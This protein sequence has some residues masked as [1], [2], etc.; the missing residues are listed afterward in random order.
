MGEENLGWDNTGAGNVGLANTGSHNV[1]AAFA[2]VGVV[3][4]SVHIPFT[5]VVSDMTLN[6]FT[7]NSPPFEAY[8]AFAPY[9]IFYD[10]GPV[11]IDTTTFDPIPLNFLWDNTY[12]YDIG[13]GTF[14]PYE[15]PITDFSQQRWWQFGLPQLLGCRPW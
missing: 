6:E 14:G 13:P 10:F 12:H 9:Y 7:I 2:A 1:G 3:D 5:G 8:L 11:T 15:I 4:I